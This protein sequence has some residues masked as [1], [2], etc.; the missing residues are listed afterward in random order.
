MKTLTLTKHS[1]FTLVLLTIVFSVS[2]TDFTTK[3][4]GKWS[5]TSI[6]TSSSY[7]GDVIDANETVYIY[8]DVTLDKDIEVKGTLIIASGGSLDG[9]SKLKIKS[10]GV[11]T[12]NGPL[13]IEKLEANGGSFTA[14]AEV[15]I[16]EDVKAED[17]ATIVFS[18]FVYIKKKLEVKKGSSLT[19]NDSVYVKEDIKIESATV[20]FNNGL[21]AKKDI[22][23]KKNSTVDFSGTIYAKEGVDKIENSTVSITGSFTAKKDMKIDKSAVSV[24]GTLNC[25]QD[26]EIKG[27]QSSLTID[28]SVSVTK[29]FKN[30]GDISVESSTS[31]TGSLYVAGNFNG[32]TTMTFN[33]VIL[34]DGWHYISSPITSATTD[35]LLGGAVYSYN[36]S[37]K[38]WTAH[39]TNESLETGKGYDVYYKNEHRTL[40]FTGTPNTGTVTN[41]LTYT[42]NT[43]DGY[44]LVGNPYPC[45]IDWESISGWTK[46]NVSSTIYIWDDAQQNITTYTTGGASTNGGS[47]V[48]PPTM[49]FFVKLN[50]VGT[51][52][53]KMTEDVKVSDVENFRKRKVIAE[54]ML[55]LKIS[56]AGYSDE[57]VLRFDPES[58]KEL[59]ILD[60]E[61]LF[62]YNVQVPQIYTRL[63]D[64][65]PLAV[66]ALSYNDLNTSIPVYFNAKIAGSYMISFDF[67]NFTL[68]VNVYLEDRE[69]GTITDLMSGEYSFESTQV[70]NSDRFVL[71]FV[72]FNAIENENT[73]YA[74]S[75]MVSVEENISKDED[76]NVF[77]DHRNIMI[78]TNLQHATQINV[79]VF[80]TGGKMVANENGASSISMQNEKSGIYLV[81]IESN[82]SIFREKVFIK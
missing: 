34:K 38:S 20:A 16:S 4:D 11:V 67:K 31:N 33:R 5:K 72:P 82:N 32:S 18:D 21:Y 63:N 2:A 69:N 64:E 80:S 42:S 28:G 12:A 9:K 25:I 24:V 68:P 56:G 15:Y 7:P 50:S 66:N 45:A 51:G 44:H 13:S 52:V 10:G 41:N 19:F 81:I 53:L 62:S 39:G 61:K 14:N 29:D 36:E 26:L 48:I 74:D 73:E 47:A 1:L 43:G 59:D 30:E 77:V 8:N 70:E 37:N 79:K 58:N 23:I 17:N 71:H 57:T 75:N 40:T 78:N 76:Y 49:A 6:W 60:A 46:T 3:K 55:S 35:A 22:E 27:S 54:N 65:F